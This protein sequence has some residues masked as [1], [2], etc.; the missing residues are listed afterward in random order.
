[1]S[2]QPRQGGSSEAVLVVSVAKSEPHFYLE[3][4]AVTTAKLM[5][6]LN[7][8][9]AKNPELKLFIRADTDAPFG[10]VIKVL[11]AAK[12]ANIKVVNALTKQVGEK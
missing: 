5:E 1:M 3:A 6:E 2:T 9:A 8:R 12:K 11:D 10:E 7:S 4:K